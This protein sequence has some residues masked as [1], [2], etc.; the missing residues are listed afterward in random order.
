MFFRLINHFLLIALSLCGCTNMESAKQKKVS[1][2]LNIYT[3]PP[4][5]DPRKTFD[6]VASNTLLFLFD[7]LTRIGFDNHPHLA[8]AKDVT[9]SNDQKTYTFHLKNALWSNGDL[10]TSHDFLFAWQSLLS[11]SFDSPSAYKLFL[12]QNAKKIKG[13]ELPLS[14]L[15]VEVPDENTLIVHLE[16]PAPYFL[17]LLSFSVFFP[18]NQKIASLDPNWADGAGPHYVSNGPFTL[19]SWE[20]E[21]EIVLKKNPLYWDASVVKIEKV[22]LA[23]VGDTLTEYYLF[24]SGE[25]DFAG[26]PC[27]NLPIDVLPTLDKEGKLGRT[28]F[29]AIYYY[30]F[31]TDHFPLQNINIRKGLALSIDRGA[32]VEHVMQV[33]HISATSFVPPLP[34]PLFNSEKNL[35]P[36]SDNDSEK[37]KK[38]FNEGLKEEG[39]NLQGFPK[40][41]LS[42]NANREHQRV[43]EAIQEQWN[44]KLGIQVTLEQF[45]W[46]VF[47]NKVGKQDYHIARA[48][49]L[50][51]YND[52]MA[53]LTIF[54]SRGDDGLGADNQT[55]WENPQFTNLLDLANY[56]KDPIKRAAILVSA[57][58]ILMDEMP[59]IPIYYIEGLYIKSPRLKD[60]LITSCGA[61][62]FK[63][64]YFQ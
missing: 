59:I 47:L 31:N 28:P 16:Y 1:L 24:E 22:N 15:G 52:P 33:G 27:S 63:W 38:L 46:K 60:V 5:L 14:K 49:W 39:I 17:E 51:E 57:E 10:L 55:G 12:I 43:A 34:N 26:S 56:E 30:K 35:L 53:F 29:S 32:I 18:I 54:K 44:K 11:P 19:S 23:M 21:N 41:I 6:S 25:L 62:D 61:I 2:H 48:A 42:F 4:T 64:A 8:I 20:Y 58:K 45:D 3:D 37:G 7:G 50:G 9:I 13:G 40:L 36:I